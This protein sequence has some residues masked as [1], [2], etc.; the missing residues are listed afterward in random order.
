MFGGVAKS[1]NCLGVG[2]AVGF[3][4]GLNLGVGFGVRCVFGFSPVGFGFCC[5]WGPWF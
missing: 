4:V 3:G 1:K 2:V 5:W